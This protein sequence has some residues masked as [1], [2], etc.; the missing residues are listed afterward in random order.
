MGQIQAAGRKISPEKV[1]TAWEVPT[2]GTSEIPPESM[3]PNGVRPTLMWLEE[4]NKK[5]GLKHVF[6]KHTK[7]YRNA[8]LPTDQLAERVPILA[9]A[10]TQVGRHEGWMGP[11]REGGRP[12]MATFMKDEGKVSRNAVQ[13]SENGFMVSIQ[14]I[15]VEKTHR[16]AGDPVRVS[17]R[18]LEDLYFYPPN[19]PERRSTHRDQ[20]PPKARVQ[21]PHKQTTL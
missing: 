2:N 10:S 11:Q 3:G 4:G 7:S 5:S 21:P 20:G 16:V 18:T 9:E 6:V 15:S 17:D 12:V 14:P 13:I 19:H 8:G 1:I